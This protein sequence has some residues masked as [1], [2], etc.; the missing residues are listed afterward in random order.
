MY[1]SKGICIIAKFIWGLTANRQLQ[2]FYR[3]L[4]K[5]ISKLYFWGLTYFTI[6][7][8]I[9]NTM[10]YY[11]QTSFFSVAIPT[12]SLTMLSKTRPI[13][14]RNETF[15]FYN[16]GEIVVGRHQIVIS[17]PISKFAAT[18]LYVFLQFIVDFWSFVVLVIFI[19]VIQAD[20]AA[21]G[22][23]AQSISAD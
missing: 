23:G 1:S 11:T 22:T 14:V 4:M 18:Y 21:G 19:A 6:S 15:Y 2:Q 17:V 9:F 3:E 10:F 8:T 16:L 12:I 5:L 13:S 20:W 7:A